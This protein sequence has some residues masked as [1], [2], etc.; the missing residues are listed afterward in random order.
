MLWVSLPQPT[1]KTA[2]SRFAREAA[3]TAI[4]SDIVPPWP[5]PPVTGPSLPCPRDSNHDK[6]E[7]RNDQEF[8][9]VHR[10]PR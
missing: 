3:V 8:K 10:H 4:R 1:R 6:D 7:Q 5:Q 9:Q 2:V